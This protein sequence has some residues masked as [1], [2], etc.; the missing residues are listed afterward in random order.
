MRSIKIKLVVYFSVLLVAIVFGLCYMG[1]S[2]SN[3]NMLELADKQNRIKVESDINSF[4]RFIDFY[5]GSRFE[6]KNGK[7]VS[8]KGATINGDFTCVNRAEKDMN[9]LASVYIFQDRKSVV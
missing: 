2:I 3:K 9:D 6:I 7:L 8:I 1:Y 5:Y 4:D